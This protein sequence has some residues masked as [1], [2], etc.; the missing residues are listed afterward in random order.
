[1]AA[2]MVLVTADNEVPIK[3]IHAQFEVEVI[4]LVLLILVEFFIELVDSDFGSGA[5]IRNNYHINVI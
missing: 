1:M 2:Q 4:S 3:V 5:V